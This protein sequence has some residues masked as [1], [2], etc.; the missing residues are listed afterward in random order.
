MRYVVAIVVGT[1]LDLFLAWGAMVFLG[2]AAGTD[3][4]VPTFGYWT[5]FWLLWA[6]STPVTSTVATHRL[7]DGDYG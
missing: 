1:I 5:C 2:V 4:R 7:L 6:L 3:P